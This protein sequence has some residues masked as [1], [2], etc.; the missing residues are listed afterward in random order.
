MEH[1]IIL[2]RSRMFIW[3]YV[4]KRQIYL[5]SRDLRLPLKAER[6]YLHQYCYLSLWWLHELSDKLLGTAA[7]S[8]WSRQEADVGDTMFFFLWGEIALTVSPHSIR[9]T[10]L[11]LFWFLL[12]CVCM[13][14]LPRSLISPSIQGSSSPG[15]TPTWR[16]TSPKIVTPMSSPTTTPESSWLPS[17]VSLTP[18]AASTPQR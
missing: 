4:L 11:L 6:R 18:T 9:I 17:T 1:L 10:L 16:W 2:T 3:N 15:N 14:H 13:S 7:L 12:L 5:S 8:V